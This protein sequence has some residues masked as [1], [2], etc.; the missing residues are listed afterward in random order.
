MTQLL[1]W[2]IGTLEFCL[3]D[4]FFFLI[5][6][7]FF[8]N[9]FGAVGLHLSI[10]TLVSILQV[11]LQ[12]SCQN[13][14]IGDVDDDVV[15]L[16]SSHIVLSK[17]GIVLIIMWWQFCA[18]KSSDIVHQPEA[19]SCKQTVFLKHKVRV[20]RHYHRH[21]RRHHPHHHHLHYHDHQCCRVG[22]HT[23]TK[24]SGSSK[25]VEE[26][27]SDNVSGKVRALS[28]VL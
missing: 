18:L 5:L 11:W 10:V 8:T 27:K 2:K 3:H 4:K 20:I 6:H 7:Q 19:F 25:K 22:S 13:D 16:K 17:D 15:G 24:D 21:H 14:D 23:T 1:M 26:D 28:S 12:M 9:F